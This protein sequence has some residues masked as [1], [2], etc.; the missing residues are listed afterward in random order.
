MWQLNSQN[1][2]RPV[3]NFSPVTPNVASELAA[4]NDPVKSSPSESRKME[5]KK[6]K[7]GDDSLDTVP[8][9]AACADIFKG[10]SYE[11]RNVYK[12][13]IRNMYAYLKNNKEEIIQI[14]SVAGFSA[15]EIEHAY[16]RLTY[17][18]DSERKRGNKK[19]AH[20]IVKKMLSQKGIYI[21]ILRETLNAMLKNREQ[22]KLGRV[23]ERNFKVYTEVCTVC[24]SETVRV[25]GQPAQGTSYNL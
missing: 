9:S 19:L 7:K 18:N 5:N 3:A 2:P 20:K 11:Y 8:N 16:F 14:L 17:Y 6:E 10:K 4:A 21:Y 25:I 1:L 24:Y 12:S 22:G 15:T 13:V 23:A